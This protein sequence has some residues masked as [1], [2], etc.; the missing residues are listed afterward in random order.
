MPDE[1][2]VHGGKNDD[3]GDDDDDDDEDDDDNDDDDQGTV[4]ESYSILQRA[5]EEKAELRSQQK[6][7]ST[8]KAG[9][10]GQLDTMQKL[11]SIVVVLKYIAVPE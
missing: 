3:G 5:A 10:R 11:D 7:V 1:W 2:D 8:M 4:D 9:E 6:S